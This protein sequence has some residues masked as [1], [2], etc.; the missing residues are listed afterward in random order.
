MVRRMTSFFYAQV[1]ISSRSKDQNL[2]SFASELLHR[3][4]HH[5]KQ[6]TPLSILIRILAFPEETT[7]DLINVDSSTTVRI[8]PMAVVLRAFLSA[9]R[10]VQC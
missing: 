2:Y 6:I 8:N 4:Q 1:A 9:V 5:L 3:I 10:R 7:N